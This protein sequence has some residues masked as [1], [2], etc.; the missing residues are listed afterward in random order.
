MNR[1]RGPKSHPL[2]GQNLAVSYGTFPLLALCLCGVVIAFSAPTATGEDHQSH[3]PIPDNVTFNAHIRPIMSNTCFVCHGPDVEN[4]PSDFLLTSFETATGPLPSDSDQVGIMPGKPEQSEVYL[5]ITGESESGEQM[6]P[7][8]FHHKLSDRDKELFHRW[9]QQGAQYEQ[10][11][12]Y[13]PI[14]RP[15]VPRP[16]DSQTANPIDGFIVDRLKKDNLQPSRPADR[17]TLI[18]RLSLDLTGL[19]PTREQL[20]EFLDDQSDQAYE[21][22]VER[23]LAAP[24]YG[25]RMAGFWLDLVRFADTVGFHGDQNQRIFPYRDYVI[26]AFNN[27]MPFNQFTREQLAGDL[28]PNPTDQQLVATGFLRLNMMTREGGAQP[29]EYLAKYRADRVRTLGT[30]FLGSTL[31]CCECHDHKYDPFSARDFYSFGAFFS[32]LRQWGVYADY[33]YTPNVELKKFNNDYPFPPEIRVKS[34]SLLAEIAQQQKRRDQ[35]LFKEIGKQTHSEEGFEKWNQKLLGQLEKWPSGWIPLNVE[36]VETSLDSK[37]KVLDDGSIVLTG[38]PKY[39]KSKTPEDE[40]SKKNGKTQPKVKE[41]V[42]VTTR[43][44]EM[45]LVNSIRLEVIPH[46][47]HKNYVG[48]S[49]EGRFTIGGVRARLMNAKVVNV[50]QNNEVTE[51]LTEEATTEE[52]TTE[53]ATTEKEG[54]SLKFAWSQADRRNPVE[55]KGGREN[56]ELS[57]VWRSGPTPWQLPANEAQL[58]H[59]AVY[60]FEAPVKIG[61]E[62]VLQIEIDSSDVGQVRLSV[63]PIGQAMA[64]WDADDGSL[65]EATALASK[66]RTAQQNE[67]LVSAYHRSTVPLEKQSKTS[68]AFRA[69]IVKL[70]SGKAMSLV[71]QA[72]ADD[73][74][75]VS[76]VLPRGN[77]QDETGELAPPGFPEF[78]PAA[79]AVDSVSSANAAKRLSRLEL[80]NWITSSKNPLTA[81]HFV[82]RTWKQFFGAG[83]SG[84]IDDLGNQGEWPSHPLLLDWMASE[85][86]ESGWDVKHLVRLIV[87]SNTYRQASAVR[88][89]LIDI[90]PYNRLLSQQSSRRLEAEVIRD[91][92]LSIAGLLV[93][94]YVGGPSVFPYQPH[95]HYR[96]LQ[97]PSREYKSSDDWRQYRRGVYMHWQR[98]FL[99]PMLVNFDAPSRDECSADRPLSNSPQQALTLLN[100]PTFVEASNHLAASLIAEC[101]SDDFSEFLNAAY[102]KA[103]SRQPTPE[104][105]DGLEK[106]FR[107]QLD[108]YQ[109]NTN[110]ADQLMKVGRVEASEF[111]LPTLAAY[112]QVCRVILNL[113][114]TITRY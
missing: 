56:P 42:T 27:N 55:Y 4:N 17:A 75:P 66:N 31:G 1:K 85:F 108:Y 64:G 61:P 112:G 63:T 41:V 48:R 109:N 14:K 87:T 90:D 77:W 22:L 32:D 74:I 20:Q 80:A 18:R 54:Q 105:R 25:E 65:R 102:L 21:K 99:H 113:H 35:Q 47:S 103:L 98:T 84:V 88:N 69:R 50:N 111:D 57:D 24:Q 101:G 15:D 46:D 49:D 94:D 96:P 30:A 12:A 44:S 28:L 86:V 81:R 23:L 97:F 67:R 53:E 93:T 26:N 106:F 110:E 13:A 114:E 43:V 95:G 79:D 19:P 68:R 82:N 89:D 40:T 7:A 91:N 100:D 71:A 8:D 60:H 52:A 104:E 107:S 45:M 73:K 38:E 29:G 70:R 36:R 58:T 6:P 72:V 92:A 10:H 16:K 59:T 51:A 9:I 78:L 83:L 3:A 37:H 11:W 62:K 34:D 2:K 5:R 76:R 39:A 33:D